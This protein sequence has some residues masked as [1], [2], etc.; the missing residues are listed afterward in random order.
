[1]K[2]QVERA[3]FCTFI[4]EFVNSAGPIQVL[5]LRWDYLQRPDQVGKCRRERCVLS[6]ACFSLWAPHH[7]NSTALINVSSAL[8]GEY[9][10]SLRLRRGSFY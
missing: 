3:S 1:M 8:P 4:D 6:A 2:P 7:L 5:L 10:E 9:R